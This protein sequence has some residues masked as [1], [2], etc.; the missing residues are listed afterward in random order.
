MNILVLTYWSYKSGLVQA[1]TL[2]YVRLIRSSAGENSRIFL[3]TMEQPSLAMSERERAV[4]K[5]KLHEEGITLIDFPY[6]PFGIKAMFTWISRIFSLLQLC[7]REKISFIHAFCTPV[8]SIGYFLS[9]LTGIPL[10]IDSYEPHAEAMVENGTWKKGGLAHRLLFML[11]KLQSRRAYAVLATVPEMKAYTKEKYNASPPHF[12]VRP[13]CADL[14]QF[15]LSEP[16]SKALMEKYGLKEGDI[17]CVYAGKT[18][19]IYLREEIFELFKVAEEY[20]KGRL[21][22]LF[23]TTDDPA[24]ISALAQKAGLSPSAMICR[25]I[26]H[27]EMPAHMALADFALNPVMPVPSKRYCISIKGAEYWAMGLPVIIPPNISDDSDII[28]E[29][30]TGVILRG[31]S[32]EA[33]MNAVQQMDELLRTDREKLRL[34][35]RKLAEE[36]RNFEIA[37]SIYRKIYGKN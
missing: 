21:R 5:V 2:P 31:F 11:E 17:V 18:G 3:V 16:R 13:A 29:H 27:K 22:V 33:Y 20:W 32:R 23:L 4:E 26:D 24:E 15:S 6:Q 25:F 30:K 9:K 14:Q 28:E 19:G 12:F 10:V 34:R 36:R 35:I 37:A 7:R 8:G 1:A